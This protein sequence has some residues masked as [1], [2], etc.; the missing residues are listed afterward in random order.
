DEHEY[1]CVECGISLDVDGLC[2]DCRYE[3]CYNDM[4]DEVYIGEADFADPSGISA[5]RAAS[6][7]NPRNLP[8]P[9]CGRENVLTPADKARGYQCD[10]CANEAEMGY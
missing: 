5:L 3:D 2:E 1:E 6:Q 8:C 4:W 10:H 7:S 9:N